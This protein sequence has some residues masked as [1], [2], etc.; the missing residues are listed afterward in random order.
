[1]SA[2][3]CGQTTSC[4]WSRTSADGPARTASLQESRCATWICCVAPWG[5]TPSSY[6]NPRLPACSIETWWMVAACQPSVSWGWTRCPSC[7]L[8]HYLPWRSRDAHGKE[9][10]EAP[11]CNCQ[12]RSRLRQVDWCLSIPMVEC[13]MCRG[14]ILRTDNSLPGVTVAMTPNSLTFPCCAI[15][16][17]ESGICVA[18][19]ASPA[20]ANNSIRRHR[21]DCHTTLGA[22]LGSVGRPAMRFSAKRK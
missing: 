11:R 6:G 13:R 10:T 1:M 8:L 12:K 19:N 14:I 9:A 15:Q 21:S 22:S 16:R 4:S 17:P 20:S 7:G 2:P 18:L 3:W 5:W